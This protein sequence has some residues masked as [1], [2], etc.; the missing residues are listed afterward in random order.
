MAERVP[1]S[2]DELLELEH[3]LCRIRN[4]R[5]LFGGSDATIVSGAPVTMIGKM[6]DQAIAYV[7]Q[8]FRKVAAL[9]K[10][11]IADE[12]GWTQQYLSK[13]LTGKLSRKQKEDSAHLEQAGRRL[14]CFILTG[15]K[16]MPQDPIASRVVEFFFRRADGASRFFER[17]RA[18]SGD[19]WT[20]RELSAEIRA[21]GW[22]A[23]RPNIADTVPVLHD[24]GL[25]NT[26]EQSAESVLAN[27]RS[28]QIVFVSDGGSFF[29]GTQEHD[30][31]TV[32]SELAKTGVELTFVY[33][34]REGGK[35]LG[36]IDSVFPKSE[37]PPAVHPVGLDVAEGNAVSFLTPEF[38]YLYLA[39]VDEGEPEST[40][41]ILRRTQI[42]A[43]DA[44]TDVG[45]ERVPLAW[46]GLPNE[47]RAFEEWIET[48][49]VLACSF[50]QDSSRRGRSKNQR[51]ERSVSR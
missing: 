47:K 31:E 22:R 6:L 27:P 15:A 5:R 3:Y 1:L 7:K 33:P 9:Q 48:T 38:R 4:R 23:A 46:L 42:Q 34:L 40:L 36:S 28:H 35:A 29:E 30:L 10:K 18:A 49:G 16:R 2:L 25:A 39:S 19:A 26:P 37:R 8:R 24:I 20:D 41:W 32:L 21:I 43:N 17:E 14:L 50:T 12:M 44:H 45:H 13:F 51:T 11:T